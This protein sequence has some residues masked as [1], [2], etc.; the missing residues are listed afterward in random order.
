MDA[1]QEEMICLRHNLHCDNYPEHITSAPRNLDSRIEDNI[2]QLLN[3]LKASLLC[4]ATYRIQHDQELCILHP[5]QL[6]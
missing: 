6:W 4:Q 1:Y 3:S 5:L 2:D